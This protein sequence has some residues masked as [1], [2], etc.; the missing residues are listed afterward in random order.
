MGFKKLCGVKKLFKTNA[1]KVLN[2]CTKS[3][4]KA[5][6]RSLIITFG[7]FGDTLLRRANDKACYVGLHPALAEG[8]RYG[9]YMGL[10]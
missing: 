3:N 6:G 10:L 5:G 7:A 9:L 4:K 8:K 1:K 2:P